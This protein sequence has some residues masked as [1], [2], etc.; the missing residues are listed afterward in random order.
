M[1]ITLFSK[2]GTS[3]AFVWLRACGLRRQ[4]A[5]VEA[6]ALLTL[7]LPNLLVI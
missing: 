5:A 3:F 7:S 6:I 2:F 4:V 1:N